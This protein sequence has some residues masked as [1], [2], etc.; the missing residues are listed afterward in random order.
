MSVIASLPWQALVIMALA[1][2]FGFLNGL[3]DSSNIVATMIASQAMKPRTA[4]WLTAIANGAGPFLFGV[5]VAT[6]IGH[7]VVADKAI[8][9]PV[10]GSALT[11]AVVWNILTWQLGI[12]SSSSHSLIGGMVGAAIADAGFGALLLGGLLKVLV[13]LF[14]SPPLGLAAGYLVM[15]AILVMSRNL[16]F[17]PKVN[18]VLRR[19][20]WLTATWLA[21]SHGANDGQ[22]TMGIL[23]MTLVASGALAGFAVPVWVIAVSAV[24]IAAGTIF[25]G[26]SLI[27]AL[28]GGFYK[29]RP[30]H[31]LSTQIASAGVI[32][33]AALLGG[34]VSTT[35]VV[36]SAIVGAGS[37]ERINKVRWGLT[38]RFVITWVLTIPI[39]A[40]MGGLLYRFVLGPTL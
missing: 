3:H 21:L 33:A 34:P 4:L 30:I 9:L 38:Q 25:G 23:T 7:E 1:L 19:G 16:G 14:I 13:A 26:W 27:K 20:Q 17:S 40:L 32:L 5:A 22:K 28:G 2:V 31:S 11:A 36:G 6:T 37:A 29:I 15:K 35:Q 18:T 39:S 10:I 8:T 12:P 24:A